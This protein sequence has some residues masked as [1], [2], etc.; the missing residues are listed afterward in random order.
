MLGHG[1]A[2]VRPWRAVC[3]L[4]LDVDSAPLTVR[5]N[6]FAIHGCRYRPTGAKLF[7]SHSPRIGNL[8]HQPSGGGDMR[9]VGMIGA[10]VVMSLA[11]NA[12]AK[13][14]ILEH[15]TLKGKAADVEFLISTP[16]TC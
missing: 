12:N 9:T 3:D 1:D 2:S 15:Q 13:G 8:L 16:E 14:G 5:A 6:V 10:A 11:A 7:R 4:L